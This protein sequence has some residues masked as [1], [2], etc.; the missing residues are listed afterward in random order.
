MFTKCVTMHTLSQR[1]SARLG[2]WPVALLLGGIPKWVVYDDVPAERRDPLSTAVFY[3]PFSRGVDRPMCDPADMPWLQQ[4]VGASTYSRAAGIEGEPERGETE[5]QFQF[6]PAK[7]LAQVH[8]Q[9]AG[10]DFMPCME[11][12]NRWL[13][14]GH[15]KHV[16]YFLPAGSRRVQQA[17]AELSDMGI[18]PGGWLPHFRSDGG[19]VL[20]YQ[21]LAYDELNLEA[22][23][24][25]GDAAETLLRG[26]AGGW[27]M[28]RARAYPTRPMRLT[29]DLDVPARS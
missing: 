6:Q 15:I 24:V 28:T 29:G 10:D 21:A 9:H 14:R 12:I 18:F 4:V 25:H 7:H 8:V 23:K 5:L 11:K 20:V 17:T 22:I 19:D 13:M 27:R 26:V 16:T 2:S 3:C 1:T